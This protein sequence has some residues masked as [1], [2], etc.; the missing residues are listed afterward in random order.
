MSALTAIA[1][2]SRPPAR[3]P[4]RAK[5][6]PAVAWWVLCSA[7]ALG[8]LGPVIVVILSS[9][10]T[11][12]EASSPNPTLFPTTWSLR[13][14]T[15]LQGVGEGMLTY[16]GNSVVV[17]LGTVI[18][19]VI[20]ATMA[21]YGF[22]KFGFYGRN[23]AFLAIVA[24][25]MVPFQAVVTPLYLILDRMG[26]VNDFLG[27]TLVY[28]TYQ[29]PF[30]IFVMRN[31]FAAVPKALEE[32]ATLD[33]ASSIRMLTDVMVP[34]VRPGLITVGLFAFFNAWNEF[35]AALILMSDQEHYTLPIALTLVQSSSFL[36]SIDWGLLQSSVVVSMVPSIIVYVVLQRY[37]AAGLLTGGVK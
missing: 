24:M 11:T 6:M 1:R 9:F 25:L 37:Y 7:I 23:A 15:S 5:V 32:A 34:L 12:A 21:G 17:A 14:Y 29:L 10:K 19:T 13:N 3:R 18:G 36:G 2:T 4:T 22:E 20:V 31:S 33:G 30:A 8:F 26:L 28:I 27:L 35:F 16:A